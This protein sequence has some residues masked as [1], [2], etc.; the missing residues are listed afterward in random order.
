[1]SGDGESVARR[2]DAHQSS[3]EGRPRLAVVITAG[4]TGLRM[5]GDTPKQFLELAGRP[6]LLHA[7]D[8][9][10]DWARDASGV[11]LAGLVVSHPAGELDRTARLLEQALARAGGPAAWPGLAAAPVEGGATRQESVALALAALPEDLAAVFIHD[12]ARPLATP[13]LYSRLWA[14][15]QARG[16]AA[17]AVPVLPP[18]DTLK[19]VRHGTESLEIAGTVDREHARAVQTPQLLRWPQIRAWHERARGE[20]FAAT[21][22]AAL[23]ERYAPEAPLLGVA[24]EARNLKL[25]RPEDLRLAAAWL[26]DDGAPVEPGLRVGQGFD[27]HAFVPDRR[28]VLGG[29]E[30]PG[31]RGL[32]GHSDAD[33]L[34][35]A[36]ADALLGAAALGDIGSH[37]PDTEEAWRGA[38]SWDLLREVAVRVRAA[39]FRPVNV[40]ATVICERPRIRPRVDAMRARI[41]DALC[42]PRDAVNVK[43]TTTEGLGFPGRGEGI[44]AQAVALLAPALA[45]R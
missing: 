16:D 15:F 41:A 42:L 5:G 26:R 3:G 30:F 34:L 11:E 12:G 27:V 1:M 40:D 17:G 13:S 7:L 22:D 31:E 14:A 24:G 36:I 25:T 35:H 4:G 29:V 37:F 33:V 21:D 32:A 43:G 45:E 23:A 2:L 39:G 8:A 44:A 10:L 18:G 9:A 20:G 6:L 28:L 19:Q 38:D